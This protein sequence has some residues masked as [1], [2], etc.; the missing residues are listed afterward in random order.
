MKRY[1]IERE[2]AG[3]GS[4]NPSELKAAACTSNNALAQIAPRVQWIESF[5]AGDKT[6]CH[7]LAE[8]EAAVH[9]HARLSGFPASKITEIGKVFDPVTASVNVEAAAPRLTAAS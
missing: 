7:Y 9:E 8:D 3:V 6:F 4:L 1:I 5:V 2:I